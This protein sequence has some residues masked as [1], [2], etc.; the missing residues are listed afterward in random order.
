MDPLLQRAEGDAAV[1][2]AHDDLAV[3]HVAAVRERELR[4]V[5]VERPIVT[6]AQIDLVAVD[7]RDQAEAV[8]LRL[9]GETAVVVGKST[10]RPGEHRCDRR[11][12]RKAHLRAVSRLHVTTGRRNRA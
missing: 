3:E 9:V 11:R 2:V 5:A 7:E 6:R 10:A 4:E 12:K 1:R 8:P